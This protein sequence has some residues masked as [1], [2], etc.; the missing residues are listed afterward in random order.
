MVVELDGISECVT[1]V[2]MGGMVVGECMLDEFVALGAIEDVG[3]DMLE[4][5]ALGTI[6]GIMLDE[7]IAL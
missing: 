6:V 2:F 4:F 3:V 1:D 5:V 7:F